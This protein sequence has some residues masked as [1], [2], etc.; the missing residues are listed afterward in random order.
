MNILK[1]LGKGSFGK[2]YA[3]TNKTTGVKRAIKKIMKKKILDQKT[4]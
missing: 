2:V 1:L 3:C 4:F